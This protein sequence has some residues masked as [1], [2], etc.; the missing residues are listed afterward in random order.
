MS[1]TAARLRIGART[2]AN[3]DQMTTEAR[4]CQHDQEGTIH[5]GRVGRAGRASEP[6][7]WRTWG[8]VQTGYASG[9][10]RP[11]AHWRHSAPALRTG[12]ATPVVTSVT[13]KTGPRQA[14][15]GARSC[16]AAPESRWY[17]RRLRGTFADRTS[18]RLS[19]P[20]HSWLMEA[21]A[22]NG[23]TCRRNPIYEACHRRQQLHRVASD[24]NL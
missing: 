24:H 19:N 1:D 22:P 14:T 5:I 8:L 7:A 15:A 6:A 4:A 17:T 12:W 23:T 11:G 10:S 18:W 20:S 13:A 9:R 16:G 2:H 21:A 3:A